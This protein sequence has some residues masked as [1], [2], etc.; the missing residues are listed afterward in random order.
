MKSATTLSASSSSSPESMR[1]GSG[2]RASTA[3]HGSISGE[4]VE[5]VASMR[6][7]EVGHRRVVGLVAA[8]ARG[9]EGALGRE[10]ATERLHVVAH[11]DDP[12]GERD[13]MPLHVIGVAVPVPALER[14]PE[15]VTDVRAEVQPLDERVGDLAAGRE[16]VERP[17]TDRLL[18]HP[19]DLVVFLRAPA[20][21]REG[22][23]VAHHLGR[24]SRVVD[25]RLP[26]IAISS[27]NRVATSWAWPV[28][29]MNRSSAT[30]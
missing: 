5:P 30:Q 11:M 8:L 18:D 24:I 14:A 29:P 15:R 6:E 2:S 13:R 20:G 3:S 23:D 10:E 19:H 7:E 26:R 4:P 16:V 25:E 17:L 21:G 12:H 27:P 22:D 1:W 28:Q 9:F